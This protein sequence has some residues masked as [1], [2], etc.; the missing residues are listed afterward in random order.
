MRLDERALSALRVRGGAATAAE[1]YRAAREGHS[2]HV[3]VHI[4]K[5]L[6]KAARAGGASFNEQSITLAIYGTATGTHEK[7]IG[8]AEAVVT[9]LEKLLSPTGGIG[10]SARLG[11]VP[12]S[13]APAEVVE[14]PRR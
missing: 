12:L 7:A 14:L 2:S 8:H 9:K 3:R 13:S 1:L 6:A 10:G 5:L 11:A 4:A